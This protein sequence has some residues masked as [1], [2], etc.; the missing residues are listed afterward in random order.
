VLQ[1]RRGSCVLAGPRGE[2][3]LLDA[4]ID[5]QGPKHPSTDAGP[6]AI[7]IAVFALNSGVGALRRSVDERIFLKMFTNIAVAVAASSRS[8]GS[9]FARAA[10]RT[11]LSREHV[12]FMQYRAPELIE[13]LID[14]VG[15]VVVLAFFE[16]R[17]SLTCRCVVV[18]LVFINRLYNSRMIRFQEELH[19]RREGVFEVFQPTAS[20][21]SASTTK[22]R[23]NPRCGLLTGARSV[24]GQFDCSC[25]RSSSS[26][27][28]SPSTST[29]SAPDRG[30]LWQRI[31]GL[32]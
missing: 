16:R 3:R 8:R 26:C 1:T 23:Q 25:W 19:E 24:S 7:W 18:P 22:P 20:R 14:L 5:D 28:T 2:G 29:T 6:V 30:T 32:S 15:A 13:Q 4:L 17:I 21:R 11:E 31:F 12:T 10:A 9:D 27:R